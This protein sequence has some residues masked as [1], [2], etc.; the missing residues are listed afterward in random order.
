MLNQVKKEISKD[1]KGVSVSSS[2]SFLEL[3][4]GV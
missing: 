3:M 2:D 1:V 4:G